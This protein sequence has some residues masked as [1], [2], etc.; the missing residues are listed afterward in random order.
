[1]HSPFCASDVASLHSSGEARSAH[2]LCPYQAGCSCTDL[3]H[4]EVW[5]NIL[6]TPFILN[7]LH[8]IIQVVSARYFGVMA[9]GSIMSSVCENARI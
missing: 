5:S 6:S 1:M 7:Y 4:C 3:H 2:P 9:H 8:G